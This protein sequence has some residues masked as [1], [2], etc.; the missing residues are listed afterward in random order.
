MRKRCLNST[1]QREK[2]QLTKSN[3]MKFIS[4]IRFAPLFSTFLFENAKFSIEVDIVLCQAVMS[5]LEALLQS[6]VQ[7]F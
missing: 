4:F 7:S 3:D 6:A 5:F 1:K 2:N